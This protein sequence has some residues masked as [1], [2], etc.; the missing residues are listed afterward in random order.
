ML[1]VADLAEF[2][3]GREPANLAGSL[4]HP[5]LDLVGAMFLLLGRS[6]RVTVR[7]RNSGRARRPPHGERICLDLS[8]GKWKAPDFGSSGL[9]LR[10]AGDTLGCV[11]EMLN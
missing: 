9:S 5:A 8:P 10:G 7:K 2:L 6:S 11:A 1:M 4:T 3:F